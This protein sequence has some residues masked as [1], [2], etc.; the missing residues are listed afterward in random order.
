MNSCEHFEYLSHSLV[1][2]IKG[3]QACMDAIM[4]IWPWEVFSEKFNGLQ[5]YM[6]DNYF[7]W[8][9]NVFKEVIVSVSS[10]LSQMII[11]S[12]TLKLTVIWPSCNEEC[13]SS[14]TH[15]AKM[16]G[17]N[18]FEFSLCSHHNWK[19]SDGEKVVLYILTVSLLYT[20]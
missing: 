12:K 5:K 17:A 9:L 15:D 10:V 8:F 11:K 7:T 18:C 2:V 1:L 14:S 3:R 19:Y 6:E 4:I 13:V 20:H 16:S